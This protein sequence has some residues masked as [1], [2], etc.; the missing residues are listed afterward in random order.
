MNEN[1]RGGGEKI[2]GLGGGSTVRQAHGRRSSPWLY[3]FTCIYPSLLS[4]SFF[5]C[6]YPRPYMF[7]NLFISW[8]E[9][10]ALLCS[11]NAFP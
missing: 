1:D 5:I 7:R 4:P 2:F 9:A 11:T 3:F 8:T 6:S 10:N